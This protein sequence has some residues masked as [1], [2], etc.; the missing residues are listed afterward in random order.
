MN[1]R[2]F[3]RRDEN[4]K[5]PTNRGGG[6][7]GYVDRCPCIGNFNSRL[8]PRVKLEIFSNQN[9]IESSRYYEITRIV[10]S[11]K[12]NEKS[13]RF[14]EDHR[15]DLEREKNKKKGLV[16]RKVGRKRRFEERKRRKL[17]SKPKN[18]N[19]IYNY[20][21]CFARS[22]PQGI[23]FKSGPFNLYL[24]FYKSRISGCR[25]YSVSISIIFYLKS[26]RRNNFILSYFTNCSINLRMNK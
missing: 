14:L 12:S 4:S 20:I 3:S 23:T 11:R 2:V 22:P 8:S 7:K 18:R 21:W 16:D 6:G 25:N 13:N 19:C 24:N 15:N 9:E 17:F 26:S 5:T 1:V 10:N